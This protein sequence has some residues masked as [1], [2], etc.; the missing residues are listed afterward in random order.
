MV[1]RIG[2]G[3]RPGRMAGDAKRV[4]EVKRL[5]VCTQRFRK[6]KAG[7]CPCCASVAR[8]LSSFFLIFFF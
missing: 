4:T 3:L 6:G 8:L 1:L 7:L 5:G 2:G